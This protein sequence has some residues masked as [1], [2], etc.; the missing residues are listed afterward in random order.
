MQFHAPELGVLCAPWCCIHIHATVVHF[1]FV[2]LL[3][4]LD[5]GSTIY[6]YMGPV[7]VV[8]YS[9][10]SSVVNIKSL[11]IGE[12]SIS[13]TLA[14]IEPIGAPCWCGVCFCSVVNHSIVKHRRYWSDRHLHDWQ[15]LFCIW[16]IAMLPCLRRACCKAKMF[17][18]HLAVCKI[19]HHPDGRHHSQLCICQV[20]AFFFSAVALLTALLS[21]LTRWSCRFCSGLPDLWPFLFR[22]WDWNA[23]AAAAAATVQAHLLFTVVHWSTTCWC[24]F[25]RCIWICLGCIW[26]ILQFLIRSRICS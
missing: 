13:D 8:L 26:A 2:W 16:R 19:C 20:A 11:A 9:Y 1:I 4:H 18:Y 3:S 15:Q 17:C 5:P 14:A 6:P 22:R 12:K 7:C 25:L 10:Y 23:T 24:L 21:P